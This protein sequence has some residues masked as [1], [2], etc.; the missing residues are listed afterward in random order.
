MPQDEQKQPHTLDE[1][2]KQLDD[3]NVK[4]QIEGEDPQS[5][6]DNEVPTD[7]GE[8][9]TVTDEELAA[10]TE[11][12]EQQTEDDQDAPL[13]AD[14]TVHM[15]EREV[16]KP[17]FFKRPKFW[18]MTVAV[19]LV[20]L[21]LAWFIRPSRIFLVNLV[22]MRSTITITTSTLPETGQMSALIKSVTVEIDGQTFKTNDKGQVVSKQPYGTVAISAQKAGYEAAHTS[23][24]LDFDPFFHLLGGK[25][26][27]AK[28]RDV[29][30]QLKAVGVRLKFT[31]IDWLSGLPITRGSFAVGDIMAKPDDQ[32]VVSFRLPAADQKSVSVSPALGGAYIDKPFTLDFGTFPTVSFVPQGSHMFISKR[33][34]SL[35]AYTSAL[36][37]GNS[38]VLMASS[39]NETA[40]MNI[41]YN[42]GHTYAVITTTRDLAHDSQ[43]TLLQKL[44]VLNIATKKLK[45][46]D[47][48]KW[49]NFADWSGDTLV[50]T[51]GERQ[52]G[53]TYDTQ[54][55]Q[56]LDVTSQTK[57]DLSS[58]AEFGQVR[59]ALGAVVYWYGYNSGEDGA[60]T[61][62]ELR[63]VPIKGGTEKNLA[64]SLKQLT[65]TSPETFAYQTGSGDWHEYNVNN[66]Q[67]K[68]SSPPAS[69]SRAYLANPSADGQW[70]LL[71]DKVDGVTTLMVRSVATGKESK[72]YASANI[73]GPLHWAGNNVIFRMV[74]TS[75]TADYA[76]SMLGGE[77]KK[78][79]DISLPV[80]PFLA[81]AG[82]FTLN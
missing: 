54:R 78:I 15:E 75:Q 74:S 42:P 5:Q 35:A 81:A 13:D 1:L 69:T 37:G 22:G 79:A 46:V 16:K 53:K 33:S 64:Y 57:R 23:V 80:N 8:T 43:G 32:G 39:S 10:A 38:A 6:A 72:L 11:E 52:S 63:S 36:D 18:F 41:T 62:P 20:A 29:K 31:A 7:N 17:P 49:F 50:Y 30:L 82:Y 56:S 28:V 2:E 77:P 34:G 24:L 51:V 19:L 9:I 45:A 60:D 14:N 61:G 67:V 47:T 58:A 48:G 12:T 73:A 44:Y 40:G 3:E 21:L 26:D 70:R 65:Q 71:I 55:L 76:V 27:D 25:N 59:V 4:P 68:N 66:G